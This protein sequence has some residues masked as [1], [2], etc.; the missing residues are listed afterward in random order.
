[1]SMAI[2]LISRRAEGKWLSAPPTLVRP[3]SPLPA[4]VAKSLQWVADGVA[5]VEPTPGHGGA[6]SVLI[7]DGD[8]VLL[9]AGLA[10]P[11]RRALAPHVDV[12]ILTH[13]HLPYSA[14]VADFHEAW[15]PRA[16]QRALRSADDYCEVHHVARRDRAVVTEWLA[17]SGFE[18]ASPRKAYRPGGLIQLGRHEWRL[19]AA[20]GHSPG[21]TLLLDPKRH[22]LYAADLDTADPWYGWPSSDLDELEQ[23]ANALA[24][25]DVAILLGAHAPPRRRGIRQM[26]RAAAA[27]IQERDRRVF[28][29]LREPH[30]LD[31]LVSHAPVS[32]RAPTTP[33]EQYF[34]RVMTE[35][36][37]L[38]LLSKDHVA[39]RQDGR[40][41][42][43]T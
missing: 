33:I 20:P 16:E 41:E 30:T 17:K 23:T 11:Q 32:G 36:H 37:L 13:T 10:P 25:V 29:A 26:F 1:M 40:Y 4:D 21:M 18:P 39:A 19:L 6:A 43:L 8:V 12:C 27:R 2:E 24:E 34:E 38:R 31:E 9:D 5:L 3:L 35:K 15:V 42:R 7:D 28:A 22:I 14:G